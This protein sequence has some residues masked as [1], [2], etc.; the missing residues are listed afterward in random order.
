MSWLS[1]KLRL[2][3]ER[4]EL[5]EQLTSDSCPE[6]KDHDIAISRE[7]IRIEQCHDAGV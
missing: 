3:L 2:V 7:D 6:Q 1:N 5:L 4:P